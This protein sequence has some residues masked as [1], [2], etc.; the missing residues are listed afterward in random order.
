M[1]VECTGVSPPPNSSPSHKRL[2]CALRTLAYVSD[3]FTPV[4]GELLQRLL[5]VA[6]ARLH[7]SEGFLGQHRLGVIDAGSRGKPTHTSGRRSTHSALE[8]GS[9]QSWFLCNAPQPT[10]RAQ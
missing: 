6:L 3:V 8:G 7:L 5:M 9:G 10:Q 2:P 1:L 4:I